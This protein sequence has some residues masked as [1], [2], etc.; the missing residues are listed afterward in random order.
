MQQII[1]NDIDSR[2]NRHTN[3]NQSDTYES[4]YSVA[5]SS[6]NQDSPKVNSSLD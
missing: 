1:L 4:L 2:F 6:F 5:S 3:D